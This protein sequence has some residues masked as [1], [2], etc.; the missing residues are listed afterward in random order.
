MAVGTDQQVA[1]VVGI[2]VH[3]HEDGGAAIED[4]AGAIIACDELIVRED[5]VRKLQDAGIPRIT[6]RAW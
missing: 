2:E 1:G 3:N 6:Q 5:L 4:E